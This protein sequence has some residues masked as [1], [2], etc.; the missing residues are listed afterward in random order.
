MGRSSRREVCHSEDSPGM[1]VPIGVLSDNMSRSPWPT[2][3]VGGKRIC[4][5]DFPFL[6]QKH[7]AM[8]Q[9]WR[10]GYKHIST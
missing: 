8:I 4:S 7:M 3:G 1:R 2:S 9:P 5:D 10:L 6:V